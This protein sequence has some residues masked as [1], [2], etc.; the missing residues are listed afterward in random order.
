M[1]DGPG[2]LAGLHP[3]VQGAVEVPRHLPGMPA[4][5]ERGDGDH[6]AITRSKLGALPHVAEQHLVGVGAERRRDL[7]HDGGRHT[8]GCS[9]LLR[10]GGC[11][12][13]NDGSHGSGQ[14]HR[15]A[16]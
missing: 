10:F 14:L 12:E 11:G 8:P 6:A 7:I 15:S 5:D 9:R 1:S 3:I 2:D 4:G 13:R 16:L